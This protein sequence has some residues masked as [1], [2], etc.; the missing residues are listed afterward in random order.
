MEQR[1]HA[2][3]LKLDEDIF[4]LG[5][6]RLDDSDLLDFDDCKRLFFLIEK[7]IELNCAKIDISVWKERLEHVEK[8]GYGLEYI[9]L[10]DMWQE[11][12]EKERDRM[13][14]E[15]CAKVQVCRVGEIT[16]TLNYDTFLESVDYYKNL[17]FEDESFKFRAHEEDEFKAKLLRV[18]R[19]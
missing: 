9:Q 16:E 3:D 6:L 7:H 14:R 18:R 15:I 4:T 17:D 11:R 13:Q 8:E 1:R 19:I 10:V 5:T 2:E 12:L